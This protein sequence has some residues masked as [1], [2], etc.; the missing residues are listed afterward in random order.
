MAST[1]GG[2]GVVA[3]PEGLPMSYVFRWLAI[4]RNPSIGTGI[5]GVPKHLAS[6]QP[7]AHR[8]PG[9]DWLKPGCPPGR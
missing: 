5:C 8:P 7:S 4:L 2:E 9:G 1:Y 6:G 3:R